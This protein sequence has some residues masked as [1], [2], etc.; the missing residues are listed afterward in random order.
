MSLPIVVLAGGLATRLRPLT[1][2]IPKILIDVAGRPFAG[3][4]RQGVGAWLLQ[5]S[6]L[7]EAHPEW[8]GEP[9]GPAIYAGLE[10]VQTQLLAQ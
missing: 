3:P 7:F 2:R 4:E 9:R 10:A 5:V 1:E 6:R 8:Q